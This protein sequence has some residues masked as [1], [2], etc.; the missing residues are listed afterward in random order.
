MLRIV[1]ALAVLGIVM[2]TLTKMMKSQLPNLSV[3]GAPAAGASQPGGVPMPAAAAEQ[4]KR[5][6]D[7]GVAARASE[8]TP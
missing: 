4:F 1:L 3:T 6:I 8:P 5:A 2:L 7:A